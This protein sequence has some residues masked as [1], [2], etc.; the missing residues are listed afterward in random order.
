MPDMETK[1][2]PEGGFSVTVTALVL[3]ASKIAVRYRHRVGSVRLPL[4]E[5]T[6]VA[7]GNTQGGL[8]VGTRNNCET[9]SRREAHWRQVV[10]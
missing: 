6:A 8:V 10:Q 9:K 2:K 5:A 7:F 1:V 3:G 4:G